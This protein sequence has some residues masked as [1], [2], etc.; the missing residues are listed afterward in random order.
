M[1]VVRI[2]RKGGV[3]VQDCDI[4][5]GRACTRGGWHLEKSKWHNP[6]S[7]KN[8]SLEDSLSKYENHIRSSPELYSCL[9]ELDGKVL[10]CWCKP[11]SC[12]GDIL[13]KLLNE[14]KNNHNA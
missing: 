3:I 1:E 5:I 2:R 11:K 12:H 14:K 13:I 6:F 10:G 7:A 9:E 4:Y 8:Y